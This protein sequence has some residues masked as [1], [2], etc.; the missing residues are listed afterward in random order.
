[1][2]VQRPHLMILGAGASVAACPAGEK[3]G[4]RL[5]VMK[6]FVDVLE[7]RP[8]LAEHGIKDNLR[9][10]EALFQ[11][12]S[13]D[14][15]KADLVARLTNRVWDY[16]T[17]LELP[18]EVNLYDHL[19]LSLRAKD[20]IGTFNWDPLL[21]QAYDRVGR[22]MYRRGY[23]PKRLLPHIAFLHGNVA[24]GYCAPDGQ[25]GGIRERCRK[26]GKPYEPSRL[27]Y[28]VRR[29][30][31]TTDPNVGAEWSDVQNALKRTYL[32]TIFGYSAPNADIEARD[33]MLDAWGGKDA[34][35]ME[36]FELIDIVP[37]GVVRKNW[38]EF[39]HTHHYNY[40][41][42]FYESYAGW[43]PRRAC[44][45]VFSRTLD[46]VW[47][48]KHP[49]PTTAPVDELLDWLRPYFERELAD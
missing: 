18:D 37:R 24:I 22:A 49:L 7:L 31:Y 43:H 1:M 27:L 17:T 36:E 33:L 15:T 20:V 26:C 4:H 2:R 10:F 6:N 40:A 42:D 28:P 21:L 9:D 41:T 34:R 3:H 11:D 13:D 5:P 16:F 30:G 14:A 45:D 32:V 29:K 48:E 44:E 38:D 19:V 47:T 8:L 46:V 12:L 25:K 35:V 39:I 23:D